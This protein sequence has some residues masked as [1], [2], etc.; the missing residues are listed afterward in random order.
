MTGRGYLATTIDFIDEIA[1]MSRD[2]GAT[3]APNGHR[4][5]FCFPALRNARSLLFLAV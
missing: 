5:S 3:M 1:A 4:Q 2:L